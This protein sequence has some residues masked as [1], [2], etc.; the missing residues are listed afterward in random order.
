[1]PTF[2]A[3]LKAVRETLEKSPEV[4][5]KG[6]IETEAEQLVVAAYQKEMGRPLSRLDLFT[7]ISDEFPAAANARLLSWTE[8]RAQGK[9][10]QHVTGVQVF[11][12]HEY[13]VGP[14]VLIPRPE[15]ELLVVTALDYLRRESPAARL[16]LEVG[17]GSGVI[18]I[19]LLAAFPTL[20]MVASELTDVAASRAQI[21]AMRVLG[22]G[23]NRLRILRASS[24]LE[25]MEPFERDLSNVAKDAQADFL[26][27]NPP[28]L[29][30]KDPIE[31]EV[32][33][34]EPSTALFAPPEDLLHF[35]RLISLSAHRFSRSALR[36]RRG[37][38]PHYCPKSRRR[39]LPGRRAMR[40]C[41]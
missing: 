35:Y 1:M 32:L 11:L 15:T 3:V 27:S 39:A 6:C 30:T 29:S 18:S 17:L 13:E 22:S 37:I 16:G 4:A 14:D 28:Y 33:Q 9:P 5:A 25:V 41:W 2:Q 20:E 34:H 23:A 12:D 31:P 26:I 21:N 24:A 36:V 8:E 38:C 7:R 40:W 19:E 10:L